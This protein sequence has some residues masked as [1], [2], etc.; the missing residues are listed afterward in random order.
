MKLANVKVDGYRLLDSFKMDLRDDLSLVI[1]RNNTGKTSL[2]NV[3][4]SFLRSSGS[5]FAYEDFS[6]GSQIAL[7]DAL[8]KGVDFKSL[9]PFKISLELEIE[10][11]EMD[12]LR[13]LSKVMVDLSPDAR[14]VN[15]K[16]AC[17]I[18]EDSFSRL[19]KDV[20]KSLSA[21]EEA[22]ETKLEGKSRRAE[23]MRFLSKMLNKYLTTEITSIDPRGEADH[24]DLSNDKAL[25]R[26]ILR[27][28]Y[29]SAKRSVEN[30]DATRSSGGA[31]SRS[32]SQLS[33]DYFDDHGG[34]G[35]ESE[36]FIKLVSQASATDRTFTDTYRTVFED[37][38]KKI[39]LF[40]GSAGFTD[41]IHVVSEI[42]PEQLLR[43]STSVRYGAADVS[44]PEDHN[45]LGYLNLIAII[46]EVE[47]RLRRMQRN[48]SDHTPADINLLFIEEPEAHTHPQL[49]TVFVK[50]IKKLILDHKNN[51]SLSLQTIITTHS[52]H[53]TAESDFSDIKYFRRVDD[54][55]VEARN[56]TDLEAKYGKKV[57]SYRFLKQYLTLTRA[58][59]FFAEKAVLIE[60]DTERI[61][62]RAMMRKLDSADS[63]HQMPISSQNVSV[64]EVGAH[65]QVFD[66]F[67]EFTGLKTLIITDIDSAKVVESETGKKK[68]E[69]CPVVEGTHTSNSS[70]KHFLNL[71]D[72]ALGEDGDLKQLRELPDVQK[73]LSKR[74]GSWQADTEQPSL[75]VAYQTDEADYEA[76]SYE[77]S[78][79]QLNRKFI[80]SMLDEFHGLKNKKHFKDQSKDSYFLADK[81]VNKKTHFALD[82]IY[83]EASSEGEDWQ[84][85]DYIVEGLRWLRD[86]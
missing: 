67:I 16:F 43:N 69:P 51:N 36:A 30:R 3:M 82:V 65:S 7:R 29:V 1:G 48:D 59:L 57:D 83:L 78:F 61:L 28:E 46:M 75:F 9:D 60:G 49:Q 31:H 11:N 32:L 5:T 20:L 72:S 80:E 12:N 15:I 35:E 4:A 79:I 55:R 62:M 70:L 50:Q 76:R 86:A 34:S 13:N 25:L 44:L 52:P 27:F 37:I 8:D 41:Q 56:M 19:S 39:K 53:I 24:L 42:Q 81:C 14:K 77:D 63:E 68:F 10:Y 85:P 74:S 38:V 45:G 33:S 2:L 54:E 18:T 40:G 73:K 17:E 23:I 22:T 64:V 26:T 21:I 58:E 71:K 84:V 47:I 66:D 6:L